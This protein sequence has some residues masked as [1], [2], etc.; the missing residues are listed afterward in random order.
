[1][2]VLK[3][4]TDIRSGYFQLLDKI[5]SSY[6]SLNAFMTAQVFLNFKKEF[7]RLKVF[8]SPTPAVFFLFF[9]DVFTLRAEE[10]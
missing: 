10:A 8:Y 4:L 3:R 9:L 6:N 5:R 2:F 1:M 7:L